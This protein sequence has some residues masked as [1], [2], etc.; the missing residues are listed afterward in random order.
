[1][2]GDTNR[3]THRSLTWNWSIPLLKW[4]MW[5]GSLSAGSLTIGKVDQGA[6]GASSWLVNVTNA[7]GA[8]AVN[9]Q[10]GGNS[11]TVDGAV[12]ANAGTNLNTSLLATEATVAAL[13]SRA[14]SFK[15]RSDT[16]TT[17]GN[18]TTVDTSINP[19]MSFSI[20]VKG[21]GGAPTTWDIRLEGSLDNTN[22]SQIVQHTNTD[23]DGTVKW[24]STNSSS[25]YFRSRVAGLVLG[26]ASNVVVTILGQH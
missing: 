3:P 4:I 5:D 19:L 22:F 15:T 10:D 17:T 21:T 9:I 18:G 23:G 25:L 24:S 26:P 20:Q 16:F 11:I 2:A 8:S 13:E 6:A 7:A 12:T 14:N 1:M